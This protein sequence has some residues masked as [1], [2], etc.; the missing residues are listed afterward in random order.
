M[1]QSLRSCLA[2]AF[3]TFIL[4]FFGTGAIVIDQATGGG[5]THLGVSL[6]FG[7]V[8]MALVYTLGDVSGA[9]LNPA[10]TLA[11]WAAR[12]LPGRT[13]APYIA[14][15][16]A[17]A[18]T[19]SLLLRLLFPQSPTLGATEPSGEVLPAFLLEVLLTNVLMFVI[20]SA[21]TGA[22]EKGL[23]AGI[24][25]GSVV[26]VEALFAGPMTGASMNPARSLGPA[27]VSGELGSLWLYLAAP[28][29]GA[30]LAVALCRCL[31]RPGCCGEAGTCGSP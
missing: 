8:V 27:L 21:S 2:E 15:Q 5:I 9:H 30:L 13:I 31:Q 19:A 1:N 24:V 28:G 7:L 29:I 18:I 11:F 6:T 16:C 23:T 17:G 12:R 4:V 25:I 22:K 14:S 26:G 3:G 10:V 20:L